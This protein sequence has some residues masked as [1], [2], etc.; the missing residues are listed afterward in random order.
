MV[1]LSRNNDYDRFFI[2]MK[3]MDEKLKAKMIAH[4]V[5]ADKEVDKESDLAIVSRQLLLALEPQETIYSWPKTVFSK[6]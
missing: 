1:L 3:K 6:G 4:M 5:I 2:R